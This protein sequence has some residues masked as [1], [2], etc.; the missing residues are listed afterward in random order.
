MD[1]VKN[2]KK[3]LP[4]IKENEAFCAFHLAT[5]SWIYTQDF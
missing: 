4:N 2:S 3:L 5:T 1:S